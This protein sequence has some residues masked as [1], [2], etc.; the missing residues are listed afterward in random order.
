VIAVADAFDSM[1]STRSYREAKSIPMAVD[2][3]RRGAGTQFDPLI[4]QAFI[5]ALDIEEWPLAAPSRA[6]ADLA[7]VTVQDHDDPTAPLQVVIP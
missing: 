3:L 7:I 6:P 5:R 2:E 1:T 4:V